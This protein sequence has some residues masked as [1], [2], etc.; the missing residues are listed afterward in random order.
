MRNLPDVIG[1]KELQV[2]VYLEDKLMGV[3]KYQLG[4]GD[5]L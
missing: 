4:N 3:M 2:R 5:V 1:A